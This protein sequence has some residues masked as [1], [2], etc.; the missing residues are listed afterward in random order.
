MEEG[1]TK[2]ALPKACNLKVQPRACY[3]D[4]MITPQL[5]YLPT[6]AKQCRYTKAKK[7][8]QQRQNLC[9]DTRTA[10]QRSD[11]LQKNDTSGVPQIQ[12][13]LNGILVINGLRKLI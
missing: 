2:H 4:T 6:Q 12:S 9:M 10:L 1:G 7:C 8:R 5:L 11:V 3:L 13:L